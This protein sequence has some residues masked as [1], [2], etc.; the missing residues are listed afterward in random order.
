MSIKTFDCKPILVLHAITDINEGDEL[1]WSYD[2]R[3]MIGQKEQF[4]SDYV[5]DACGNFYILFNKRKI[6]R[7]NL[8]NFKE[9][10]YN[11]NFVNKNYKT[12]Y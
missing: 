10:I 1:T 8:I 11:H 9:I 12:N 3:K 6:L 5:W 2:T 7:F 4:N